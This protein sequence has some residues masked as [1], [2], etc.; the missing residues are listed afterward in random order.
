MLIFRYERIRQL[1]S[2][3]NKLVY[4]STIIDFFI[5]SI[6]LLSL[7]KVVDLSAV[8]FEVNILLTIVVLLSIAIGVMVFVLQYYDRIF[9]KTAKVTV[10]VKNQI[11]RFKNRPRKYHY[12]FSLA[13]LK[14]VRTLN[15]LLSIWR[16]L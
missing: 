13:K 1:R 12:G 14:F 3:L 15:T 6:I 4:G 9:F 5:M 11:N 2:M 7:M 8:L 10:Q 16:K